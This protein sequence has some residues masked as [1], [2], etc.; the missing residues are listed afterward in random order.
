MLY[1]TEHRL[2]GLIG[3]H[4]DDLLC[5]G[6]GPVFDEA[7]RKLE[8]KLPFGNRKYDAFTYCGLRMTQNPTDHSIEVDQC[9]YISKLKPMVT[10]FK[11]DKVPDYAMTDY[12]TMVGGLAWAVIN[13]RPDSAFDVSWLA[14]KGP[15]S[16]KS[17][18]SFGNKVMRRLQTSTVK[19][20]YKRVS[21]DIRD[22]RLVIYHDAGWSTRPSLH[23]QA[24]AALFLCDKKVLEGKFAPA[25]LADWCCTRIARVVRSSFEAEINSAQIALDHAAILTAIWHIALYDLPLREYRE[26]LLDYTEMQVLLGDNRGLYSTVESANPVTTKGERRLTVDKIIMRDHLRENNAKYGWTNAGHQLADAFTKRSDTARCDLLLEAMQRC[27]IRIHYDTQND[28]KTKATAV[29]ESVYIAPAVDEQSE[30]SDSEE[31]FQRRWKFRIKQLHSVTR[32]A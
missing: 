30:G 31:W 5:A 26:N 8:S 9:D 11:G 27:A 16:T 7:M 25:M 13:T 32:L 2:C 19:L 12:R 28:R 24:G 20:R 3:V 14:S 10:K 4:V 15:T 18:V 6:T 17:D 21:D 29:R 22:W 1:D 23:S